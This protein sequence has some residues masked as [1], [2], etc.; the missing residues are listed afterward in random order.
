[1]LVHIHIPKNA[2]TT[3]NEILNKN[4]GKRYSHFH[5]KRCGQ[6]LS[7]SEFIE[8]IN[9]HKPH[10]DVLS[11]HDILPLD[12][13]ISKSLG[14][15]YF[16]FIRH[17]VSRAISL[18]FHEKSR[19]EKDHI[20]QY[21]FQEYVK[22]RPKHDGAISNWQTYNVAGVVDF[23]K[24]RSALDQFV[25]VGLVENFDK[26]AILL[27]E[28]MQKAGF[29]NFIILSKPANVSQNK[30]LSI[31]TLPE[32]IFENLSE[33][34]QEDIKLFEYAQNRLDQDIHNLSSFKQKEDLFKIRN[35]IYN[36]Y[37]TTGSSIKGIL[38][39]FNK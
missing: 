38:K 2:G 34:N 5:T 6:F 31:E 27:Q 12:A 21:S 8:L 10:A 22:E 25:M 15:S 35:N 3:V 7:D 29:P 32:N 28:V 23:E 30:T 9:H 1:M 33:L 13:E 24:A 17:P 20:S 14:V 16:T 36:I 37:R 26:S 11:G 18:Y 19:T 39:N 4:F